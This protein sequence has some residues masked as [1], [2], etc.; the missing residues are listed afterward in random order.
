MLVRV[1]SSKGTSRLDVAKD[2]TVKDLAYTAA[3]DLGVPL[4]EV[5]IAFDFQG[6]QKV[7]ISDELLVD[8]G[9]NHGSM[10]YVSIVTPP[11]NE[12][13]DDQKWSDQQKSRFKDICGSEMRLLNYKF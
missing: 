1:R 4:E 5:S 6:E 9:I 8:C 12:E 13:K 10:V 2:S 3:C 7:E 11:I